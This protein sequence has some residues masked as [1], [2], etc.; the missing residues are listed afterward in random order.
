MPLN[1]FV[2]CDPGSVRETVSA[3]RQL[4]S[5]V[6]DAASG[7]QRTI[8]NSEAGWEGQAGGAFRAKAGT[9]RRDADALANLFNGLGQALTAFADDLTTVKARM[10]QAQQVATSGGL[11]MMGAHLILEPGPMPLQP[12]QQQRQQ[13]AY[14]EAQET[15]NQARSMEKA[16][17]ERLA[18]ALKGNAD[19]LQHIGSAGGW[20]QAAAA[21]TSPAAQAL[22]GAATLMDDRALNATKGMFERA[23]ST[24][25]AAVSGLW[26]ALT[27]AQQADLMGRFPQM[28]GNTDGV[29]SATRDLANRSILQ[30]QRAAITNQIGTLHKQIQDE[31]ERTGHSETS[32]GHKIR[33][34]NEALRG[35]DSL[36]NKIGESAAQSDY[37]LL[38][39]DSTA[40]N[41]GQAIVAHGNPDF[42]DNT[43][44]LVP[45]T[46]SDLGGVTDDVTRNDQVLNRANELSPGNNVAITWASYESPNSV[47]P[48]AAFG[49]YAENAHGD[50]SNFQEGLRASH[51]GETPSHN[52]LIGH[53]YGSTVVGEAASNGGSHADDIAFLGSPGVGVDSADQLGVP[54]EHVWAAKSESDVIDW[55]P[56]TDPLRWA[57]TV[58][59]DSDYARYGLDPTD[60]EFGGNIMPTDPNGGHS[61]YWDRAPSRESMARIMTGTNG[62]GS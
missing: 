21:A 12:D 51:Q 4:A 39:L 13:T 48:G 22:A 14:R 42:A 6:D 27:S 49:S 57:P 24:S 46:Y 45:G 16:A 60:P 58:F 7:W 1:I 59:G 44:T 40:E 26:G 15:I 41:R 23:A 37:Y 61:D 35:I 5:G 53:S 32:K 8:T 20:A 19:G 28:V 25:P 17:H 36:Q 11:R 2:A 10:A 33:E 9:T 62:Q 55:T 3:V 52:T 54:K 38:G 50:L 56:S 29:P 31:F 34:L 30:S 47:V 43:M 18:A